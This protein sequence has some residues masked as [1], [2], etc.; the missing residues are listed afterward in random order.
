MSKLGGKLNYGHVTFLDICRLPYNVELNLFIDHQEVTRIGLFCV[1]FVCFR[2][3]L[4]IFC[5]LT[6][7]VDLFIFAV[8]CFSALLL[9]FVCFQGNS[10]TVSFSILLLATKRRL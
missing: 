10:D 3:C 8:W 6:I 4:Y 7:L 2:R 5:N 1:W 9:G